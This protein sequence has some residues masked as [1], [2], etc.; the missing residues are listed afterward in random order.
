LR[1]VISFE[2]EQEGLAIFEGGI[3]DDSYFGEVRNRKRG[4]GAVGKIPVFM[5]FKRG[6]RFYKKIIP[7]AL[8]EALMPIMN[9]KLCPIASSILTADAAILF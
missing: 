9:R 8:C 6:G 4:G 1:E 2:L 3:E 7:D 5:L